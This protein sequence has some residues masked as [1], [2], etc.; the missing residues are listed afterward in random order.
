MIESLEAKLEA[1]RQALIGE[2]V[3]V[4]KL[5]FSV[6]AQDI[7][8][9]ANE[10]VTQIII[11]GKLTPIQEVYQTLVNLTEAL[12]QNI[13]PEGKEVENFFSLDALPAFKPSL[14]TI[15]KDNLMQ[16]IRNLMRDI[17]N[18]LT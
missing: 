16:V 3:E 8:K 10:P 2:A 11:D 6:K 9:P 15:T 14:P 12:N 18:G 13:D 4:S 1:N 17:K 7:D 5:L